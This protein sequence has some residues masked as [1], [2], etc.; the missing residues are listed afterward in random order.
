MK[1]KRIP[2]SENIKNCSPLKLPQKNVPIIHESLGC[3]PHDVTGNLHYPE[4]EGLQSLSATDDG[5]T[6]DLFQGQNPNITKREMDFHYG[7]DTGVVCGLPA[8][9]F[10][11]RRR[12]PTNSELGLHKNS[13]GKRLEMPCNEMVAGVTEGFPPHCVPDSSAAN[14]PNSDGCVIGGSSVYNAQSSNQNPTTNRKPNDRIDEDAVRDHPLISHLVPMAGGVSVG[15]DAQVGVAA[16][17]CHQPR[18]EKRKRCADE[19]SPRHR[20]HIIGATQPRKR[21]RRT[22]QASTS[23]ANDHS[24]N[25]TEGS[26]SY[27]P[28]DTSSAY[29]DLGDCTESCNY[30]NAIFWRGERLAGHG[31]GSHVSRY[32]L[33]CSNGK[34]FMQ[35]EPDPPEYIKQLLGNATFM[36]NIRAYNQM[37]VMTSFGT[38]VD[39]TVNQERGPYVFKVSGQI[40][41]RIGSLCPTGDDD[42]K[43]LQLYIYDTKNEVR[44]RLNPFSSSEHLL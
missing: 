29:D 2:S 5:S 43:F 42:P 11:P 23:C 14:R 18:S 31:Y 17:V 37:F 21:N 22:S 41:H 27:T 40:Y 25:I 44:N 32:H 34:V 24:Q 33:C 6:K 12:K 36:E 38:T 28:Q 16:H 35:S 19:V 26:T 4:L 3:Q 39:S 7:S 1:E 15:D 13:S 9:F 30:C 20:S 10:G 8:N